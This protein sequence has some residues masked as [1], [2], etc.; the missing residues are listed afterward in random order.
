MKAFRRFIITAIS[1]SVAGAVA[2]AAVLQ[3]FARADYTIGGEV[4]LVCGLPL[5]VYA[6]FIVGREWAIMT[7]NR[8]R[9]VRRREEVLP[10]KPTGYMTIWR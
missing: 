7:Y 4:F 3:V 9:P 6:G 2:H 1:C 10:D 8:V 5:I